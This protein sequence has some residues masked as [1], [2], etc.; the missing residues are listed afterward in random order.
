METKLEIDVVNW[1]SDFGFRVYPGNP[2][3]ST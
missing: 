1:V 3:D 2:V